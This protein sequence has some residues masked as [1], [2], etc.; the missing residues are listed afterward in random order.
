LDV[1][2]V[3][4]GAEFI[5]L[6]VEDFKIHSTSFKIA[7]SYVGILMDES[8]S[9]YLKTLRASIDQLKETGNLIEGKTS[10]AFIRDYLDSCTGFVVVLVDVE[11]LPNNRRIARGDYQGHYIIAYKMDAE[12]V[13]ILDPTWENEGKVHR[14]SLADFENARLAAGTDQSCI[15]IGHSSR[16]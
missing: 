12:V 4:L 7:D 16:R 3:D 11:K 9:G 6:G 1:C 14:V 15:F 13:S 5:R 10:L 2:I 8:Y